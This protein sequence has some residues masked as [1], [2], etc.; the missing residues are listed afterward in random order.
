MCMVMSF[1]ALFITITI[2][3]TITKKNGDYMPNNCKPVDYGI[4]IYFEIAH[5]YKEYRI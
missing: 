4:S 1:A 3:A 5:G 2:T